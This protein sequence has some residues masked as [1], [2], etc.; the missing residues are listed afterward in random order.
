MAAADSE[1]VGIC[2]AG[3][4]LIFPMVPVLRW[5]GFPVGGGT[6]MEE[7]DSLSTVFMNE[8]RIW[9]QQL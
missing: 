9:N 2:Q 1:K 7:E 3:K 6:C 8:K 5:A 4:D